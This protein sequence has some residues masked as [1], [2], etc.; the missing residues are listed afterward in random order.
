MNALKSSRRL[1]ATAAEGAVKPQ[2]SE[3]TWVES[4][5]SSNPALKTPVFP[6]KN[7]LLNGV[8]ESGP[9]SFR[10]RRG[11]ARYIPQ[12]GLNEAFDEAYK[13]LKNKSEEAYKQVE[14]IEKKLA[15]NPNSAELLKAKSSKLTEAEINNPEVQYNFRYSDKIDNNTRLI[16][17]NLPVFRAL[18]K[19][20]WENH[21]QMLLMQRLEQLGCI[22]DTLP[23]LNPKADVN[24]KFL[25]HT[26]INR[27]VEPGTLLSSNAT[28]YP[29]TVKIQEV[30]DVDTK[31][32]LYT[33][34][35][36]NPDVPDL[37][38]DSFKTH[39]QWGLS[40]IKVDYNDNVIGP[41]RLLEDSSI[42]ELIDYY[43]PVPEKNTPTQRFITWVFRQPKEITEKIGEREFDIRSYVD[44]HNLE[45]IG[46]HVWRSAWDTNVNNVRE[47]YGLPKG[48][49]F[50]RV[51]VVPYA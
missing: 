20:E 39:I 23:T 33:V 27:W 41:K 29:P 14:E 37:E 28:T 22:P 32:Q 46:A 9:P 43:P 47:L 38:N 8:P 34:L 45:A 12:P 19:K 48:I 18:R 30:E 21:D 24:V 50:G 15:E 49:V 4:K 36:V 40:N 17:Y 31:N 7:A 5:Y 13:F 44:Q 2:P 26:T 35:L 6:L 16:D 11:R 3:K 25:N 51:R 10:S 42:N 1:M